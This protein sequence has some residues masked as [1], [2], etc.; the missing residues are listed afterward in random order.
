MAERT[1]QWSTARR[2]V[3]MVE[4]M[5]RTVGRPE[6][7]PPLVISLSETSIHDPDIRR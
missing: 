4:D 1:R 2:L 5:L 6:A 7:R 3:N